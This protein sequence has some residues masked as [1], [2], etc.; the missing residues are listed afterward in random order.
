VAR[1]EVDPLSQGLRTARDGP[2]VGLR[3]FRFEAAVETVSPGHG[4]DVRQVR[5]DVMVR[6]LSGF[7]HHAVFDPSDH[8]GRTVT[9]P[10]LVLTRDSICLQ[11]R[12][13]SRA[14]L[15]HLDGCDVHGATPLERPLLPRRGPNH[16]RLRLQ[17]QCNY[18]RQ[19]ISFGRK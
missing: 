14:W 15:T 5:D 4:L 2:R 17:V 18:S 6:D 9:G 13:R 3:F 10:I 8:H 16:T 1:R 11:G 12:G 7:L 19:E